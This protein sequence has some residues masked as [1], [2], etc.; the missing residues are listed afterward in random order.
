M[1]LYAVTV[2][3]PVATPC[4]SD[5]VFNAMLHIRHRPSDGAMIQ[6]AFALAQLGD[7]TPVAR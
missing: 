7:Q 1:A 4:A 6:D 3:I 5:E 2:T